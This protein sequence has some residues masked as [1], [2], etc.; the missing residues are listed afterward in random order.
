MFAEPEDRVG[1]IDDVVLLCKAL[2]ER[3]DVAAEGMEPWRNTGL[4]WKANDCGNQGE[5]ILGNHLARWYMM[6]AVAASAGVTVEEP[7]VSPVTNRIPQIV[8]PDETHI[9]GDPSSFSWR[10]VCDECVNGPSDA[11]CKYPHG[12]ATDNGLNRVASVIRSDLQ[13]L[14]DEVVSSKV[15]A[16]ADFDDVAIHLRTGDIVRQKH[17]LYGLDP[18]HVYAKL[19]LQAVSSIGIVTAPFAQR[20]ADWGPGNPD[21]NHAIVTAAQ[22]YLQDAFPE[23]TV[24]IRND[25]NETMDVVYARLVRANYTICGPSTFC[26][27]P[28]IASMGESFILHSPLFGNSPTWIDK[29]ESEVF[30]EVH[31]ADDAYIGSEVFWDWTDPN[32]VVKLLR[33]NP[34]EGV[35]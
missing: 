4:Y 9:D 34:D 3:S 31:Y 21:M 15:I 8:R 22:E 35:S 19:I 5:S 13:R 11:L 23:A 26:L 30:P 20:R 6:R 29:V 2:L 33:E 12:V 25:E 24:S 17:S 14:A 28:A 7:C 10:S 1:F 27:F 16:D 18:F 32:D